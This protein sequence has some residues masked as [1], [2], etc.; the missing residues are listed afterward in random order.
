MRV[1]V[2]E[3]WYDSEMLPIMV[4]MTGQEREMFIN[5]PKDATR[6]ASA[7]HG[8]MTAAEASAW[9]DDGFIPYAAAPEHIE[10]N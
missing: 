8:M 9:M 3:T 2:G 4:Q 10:L 5:M 7:P 6:F 1:K